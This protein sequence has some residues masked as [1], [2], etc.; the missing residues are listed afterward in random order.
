MLRDE[1]N[2]YFASNVSRKLPTHTHKICL[3]KTKNDKHNNNKKN[4][5]ILFISL[6]K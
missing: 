2:F 1:T 5:V 4:A 3:S 6:C